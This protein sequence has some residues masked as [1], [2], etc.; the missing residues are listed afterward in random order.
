[1]NPMSFSLF[2]YYS[3]NN[4]YWNTVISKNIAV[5]NKT[6]FNIYNT[7]KFVYII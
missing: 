3:I 7:I 2:Q 4:F 5:I 6:P 1:M